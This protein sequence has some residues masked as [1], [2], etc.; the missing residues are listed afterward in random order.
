MRT[1]NSLGKYLIT[2]DSIVTSL[3]ILKLILKSNR[4]SGQFNL[5]TTSVIL[6]N[7]NLWKIVEM[8]FLYCVLS[9]VQW[10][11]FEELFDLIPPSS[12]TSAQKHVPSL[13]PGWLVVHG[14]PGWPDPSFQARANNGT[15]YQQLCPLKAIKRIN[16]L[17]NTRRMLR[18][19]WRRSMQSRIK[20]ILKS[21][22]Y[23]RP[24]IEILKTQ[25]WGVS[26]VGTNLLTCLM[27]KIR[28]S[29]YDNA[30]IV[31]ADPRV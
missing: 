30:F 28:T 21:K 19:R 18:R 9:E 29:H 13:L 31:K 17:L 25:T 15:S 5:L 24:R 27:P 10:G 26:S 3:R 22:E 12:F 1:K 14:P 23:G 4:Q 16:K 6:A 20:E 2:K 8:L 11:V 7:W